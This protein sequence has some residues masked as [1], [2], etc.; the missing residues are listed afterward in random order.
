[1]LRL[2]KTPRRIELALSLFFLGCETTGTAGPATHVDDPAMVETQKTLL[3]SMVDVGQGDGMVIKTPSGTVIAFD[4]GPDRTGNYADF[5]KRQNIT[6]IDYVILSH[7]HSDHYTGL[8]TAIAIAFA[9]NPMNLANLGYDMQSISGGRFVLGLGSQVK[10]HIEKRFSS[11][12]SHPAERMREIVLAIKA[13]WNCW[14]GKGPLDFRGEF[15][16]HTIM[17]PAFDPGPNPYGPPPVFTGGFGPRMTAIGGEVSDGFIAHPFNTRRSL[18]ENTLPAL[19]KGLELSGRKRSDIEVMCATLVVTADTDEGL[20]ASKL[21]ARKQLAFYGSTPA[22]L[23]TLACHGWQGVH[24]ELNR[25]S[26]QGRWDEMT[27]LVGD[28][29]LEEIAVVGKRH[30]IA[31]KLRARLDGIA[32]SVSI[33][34]NRCPDP[35]H[36]ADVVR[37]LK[38]L[39]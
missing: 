5:L 17:I 12:W 36:W 15:Y 14:E 1:M 27:D 28:E 34:H 6:Q 31:A 21:A 8:G 13:I 33:T 19:Q 29:I 32:D 22:Y 20:A 37:D 3:I 26:K 25:L 2:M 24:E 39:P 9:R 35:G 30:E 7:G 18:L 23:P 4:G 38:K 16:T 10:P 11:V